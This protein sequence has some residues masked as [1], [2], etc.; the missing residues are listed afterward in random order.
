MPAILQTADDPKDWVTLWPK[1]NQPEV[2]K[3]AY[4]EPDENGLFP[5]WDGPALF[6]KRARMRPENWARVYMQQQS[7]GSE[8][9]DS[10]AV[11]ASINMGRRPGLIPRGM[12]GVREGGMDN[13]VVVAGLDPASPSGFVGAVC[14]GL[15]VKTQKRYVLDVHNKTGMTPDDIRQLIKDWTEKYHITEWRIEKNAFQTMLTQDREVKEFLASRG[16]ILREHFTGQNKWDADFGVTSMT[17]LF[18]GWENGN[19]M[20]ELPR[21]SDF[22]AGKSLVEQLT[23]WRPD[24]PK[25]H[26]TDIVMALWFTELAC[27]DRVLAMTSYTKSHLNNQFATRYDVSKRQSV[28]FA[29]Y[30]VQRMMRQIGA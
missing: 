11:A 16:A 26:K 15:D 18:A 7:S 27:R 17:M 20:I 30:E 6:K 29:D 21:T 13:L 25:G 23:T 12:P 24:A 19:Q 22:E 3:G 8:I 9:F 2:T 10:D 1:S 5:K 14:I 28:N 4:R